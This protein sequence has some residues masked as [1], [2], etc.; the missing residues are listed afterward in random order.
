MQI[1]LNSVSL[2]GSDDSPDLLVHVTEEVNV[3]EAV[4]RVTAT[5]L[6]QVVSEEH[7]QLVSLPDEHEAHEPGS[8]RT[9]KFDQ[10]AHSAG[11]RRVQIRQRSLFH[12]DLGGTGDAE[13]VLHLASKQNA[14]FHE[15]LSDM[16]QR[17]SLRLP[18]LGRRRGR[19]T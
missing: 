1:K 19:C 14:V 12:V 11:Q 9:K 10:T 3:A 7:V 2:V 18:K 8:P 4:V 17:D 6:T 16:Y 13:H 15:V 5:I